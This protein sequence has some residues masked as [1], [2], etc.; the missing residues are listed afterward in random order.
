MTGDDQFEYNYRAIRELLLAAYSADELWA[1][2]VYDEEL[3]PLRHEFAP[4]D[5]IIALADKAIGYCTR[6]LLM[7]HFLG[8]VKENRPVPYARFERELR[9]MPGRE[10]S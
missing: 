6:R 4:N 1:L 3:G 9:R 10:T 5:S 7:E 2:I 8:L